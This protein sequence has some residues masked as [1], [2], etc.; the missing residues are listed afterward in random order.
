MYSKHPGGTGRTDGHSL[1]DCFRIFLSAALQFGH[2]LTFLLYDEGEYGDT[3]RPWSKVKAPRNANANENVS[4]DKYLRVK[5]WIWL[6]QMCD[7]YHNFLS[8]FRTESVLWRPEFNQSQPET[9]LLICKTWQ[10]HFRTRHAMTS[11]ALLFCA[12]CVT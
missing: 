9:R 8:H 7:I 6:K 12:A 5:I 1:V 10:L 2:L 3:S 11:S 4:I